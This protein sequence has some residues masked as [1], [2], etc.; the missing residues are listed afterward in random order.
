MAQHEASYTVEVQGPHV[1][2]QCQADKALL[3]QLLQI[4]KNIQNLK[5]E[6]DTPS[7]SEWSILGNHFSNI[8]DLEMDSGFNEDW[9]DEKLPIH[10]PIQRLLVASAGAEVVRSRFI[11]EGKVKHLTLLLTNG[12]R[13][14]GPSSKELVQLHRQ[15]IERGEKEA[16]F[17]T[18]HKGTSEERK[19]ELTVIPE[20]VAEWMNNYYGHLKSVDEGAKSRREKIPDSDKIEQNLLPKDVSTNLEK[21]EI[22]END[23]IDT[24]DRMAIA[25]P[26]VVFAISTLNLRS[27]H[28]N[29]FAYTH[30]DM[31]PQFLPQLQTLRTLVLS[32]G[33]D[34]ERASFVP[35]LYLIL[36][37]NLSVLRFRGPVSLV[38][39]EQW[40]NWI[41]SFAS[42]DYLPNL[43]TLSFVLDLNYEGDNKRPVDAPDEALREARS[44]C[45]ELYTVVRRRGV[46][47]EPFYDKWS[48][49]YQILKR[50]DERWV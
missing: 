23:A 24:F 6:E 1:E 50:V 31:F 13:F 33:N 21:L 26:H 12:L 8:Q 15:A 11:T 14:V 20:I 35:E 4:P 40:R 49:R 22:L 44:A 48:D 17:L 45:E 25:L 9:N 5:I 30:E 7:D 36:P 32:V 29:D 37:P 34:F 2:E 46:S 3:S 10:W 38:R 43:K 47:I 28:G 19:I 27:T 39:S 18:V 42:S 16:Q 41:Q